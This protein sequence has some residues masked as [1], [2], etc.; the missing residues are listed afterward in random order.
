MIVEK[1]H[2]WIDPVVDTLKYLGIYDHVVSVATKS[3]EFLEFMYSAI[4]VLL[5]DLSQG[6]SQGLRKCYG[7]LAMALPWLDR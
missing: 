4:G 6:L 5:R 3:V 1:P 2:L 7:W